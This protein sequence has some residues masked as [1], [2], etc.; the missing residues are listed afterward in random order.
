MESITDWI[1]ALANLAIAVA[2]C[3]A[4]WQGV[5]GLSTW[6]YETVGRRRVELAEDTLAAFY[7]AVA[8]IERSRDEI[9]WSP[10]MMQRPGR[11]Q[12]TDE[13]KDRRDSYYVLHLA[14]KDQREF[15]ARFQARRFRVVAAFDRDA[16]ALFARMEDLHRRHQ[17][18]VGG[19]H[20]WD[21]GTNLVPKDPQEL[22]Q[23][24]QIAWRRHERP[25]PFGDELHAVEVDAEDYFGPEL[26]LAAAPRM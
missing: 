11:E 19:L 18:A 22:E 25:D 20:Y 14:T 13:V 8:L 17:R 23:L 2:A 9:M 10:L 6:R 12:D 26:R 7:E 15:F 16:G 1:S 21:P 3:F 24:E 4:A 5:K